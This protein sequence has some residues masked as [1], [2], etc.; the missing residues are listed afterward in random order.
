MAILGPKTWLNP[1][2]KNVNFLTFWT[3]SFHSLE[4]LFFV[5]EYRQRHFAGLYYLNKKR[6]KN[7]HFSTFWTSCFY[8]IEISFFVLEY[9]KR[10]FSCL[11][12]LKKE[13][14]KIAFLDQNHGLTLF[15]NIAIFRLF[16]LLVFIAWKGVLSF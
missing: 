11:Y 8:S 1:F 12:W 9:C 13:V 15:G 7:G 2:G 16:K 4:R 5:L 3:S 6:W 10:H 14:G